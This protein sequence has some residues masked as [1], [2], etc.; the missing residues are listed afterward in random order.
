M[1]LSVRH[2]V[3]LLQRE[4]LMYRRDKYLLEASGAGCSCHPENK[5][6]VYFSLQAKNAP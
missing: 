2:E 6:G 5:G 1:D 4:K 3:A